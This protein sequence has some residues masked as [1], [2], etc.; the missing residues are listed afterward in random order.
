MIVWAYHGSFSIAEL[1]L[2]G[3]EG[4]WQTAAALCIFCGV[5]G[6]SAQFPL[7]MWLPDAME[8]PT[9]V[10]ALIHAATYGGSR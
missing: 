9:P 7:L 8:G 2:V 5:I 10:S 4:A 1:N 6:K 3:P